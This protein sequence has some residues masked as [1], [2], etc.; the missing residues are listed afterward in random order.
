MS[1]YLFFIL[2]LAA[3]VVTVMIFLPFLTPL[4]LALCTAVLVFPIYERLA[5]SLGG[6]IWA[7]RSAGLITT[8]GVLVVVLVPLFFLV[9]SIY[10]EIQTLYAMLT[11]EG[12]RSIVV[13]SLNSI[14]Q[15]FSNLVFGVI[16][17]Y[18]FDAL[19][20]TEYLKSGLEWL[21]VHLDAVFTSIAAVCAY[22]LIFLLSVFYM[23]RD[24]QSLVKRFFF[25]SPLLESNHDFI[26][27][28]MKRAIQSVFLGALLVSL[29][30]G[31]ATGIGFLIFGIPAPALWGTIAGIAALVPGIGTSIVILPAA[32]YLILSGNYLYAAGVLVWGYTGV[33][34]IDHIIGPNLVNRGLRLHP[35]L[36]LLS[37]LGG[38]LVFGIIGFVMGPIVLAV[39]SA[40][41]DIYRMSLK[42]SN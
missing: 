26:V 12:N 22:V 4:V 37:V 9:G 16:Q 20:V 42:N 39:L 33:I 2:L 25:W 8:V 34:V 36:V 21:F 14:S 31:V 38:I 6:G 41:L 29:L 3:A 40:L 13:E 10:S 11:D 35:L 27:R 19:N 5:H 30:E 17:P 28:T 15:G 32:A 24:G 23:L 1:S 18:S 7:K